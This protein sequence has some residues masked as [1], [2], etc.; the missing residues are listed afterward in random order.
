MRVV[1]IAERAPEDQR[2]VNWPIEWRIPVKGEEVI[3]PDIYPYAMPIARVVWVQRP[4]QFWEC[5]L[6]FAGPPF[7]T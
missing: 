4:G 3:F 5:Q 7:S 6:W 2:E 1:A